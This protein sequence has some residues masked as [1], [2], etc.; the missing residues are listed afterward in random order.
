MRDFIGAVISV[1]VAFLMYTLLAKIS[2][3]LLFLFNFFSLIVIYFA[4]EKG[5][6]YGAFLG[7]FCGLLQ[8]SFSLGVF[9][10]AGIA[11]TIMGYSAGYFSG[12][13]NVAPLRR[14]F[15]FIFLLLCLELII[16]FLLYSFIFSERVSTG[17]G[18][19]FFQPLMTA[20]LGS[21]GY[22]FINKLKSSRTYNE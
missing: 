15:V 11:K 16:W 13:I 14:S 21:L 8:D 10:V 18:L 12:K 4:L 17:G 2:V 3:S 19:I 1:L 5:E 7:A 6:I 9:G 22:R 20:L